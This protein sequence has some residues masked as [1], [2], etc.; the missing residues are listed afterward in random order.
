M[1]TEITL[2][3]KFKVFKW[4]ISCYD[5]IDENATEAY[6]NCVKYVKRFKEQTCLNFD[7][8]SVEMKS[9]FE[10]L[11]TKHITWYWLWPRSSSPN[12]SAFNTWTSCFWWEYLKKKKVV[13]LCFSCL[14]PSINSLFVCLPT[15]LLT[16][17]KSNNCVIRVPSVRWNSNIIESSSKFDVIVSWITSPPCRKWNEMD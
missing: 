11:D 16:F 3:S 17:R 5:T 14:H 1:A 7:M 8:A 9:F 15:Y 10:S 12:T 6:L 4:S 2:V 13:E